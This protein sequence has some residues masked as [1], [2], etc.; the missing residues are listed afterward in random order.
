MHLAAT[1]ENSTLRRISNFFSSCFQVSPVAMSI[2]GPLDAIGLCADEELVGTWEDKPIAVDVDVATLL[3]SSFCS[4][5]LFAIV[6][7]Q[8][9]KLEFL[10]QQVELKWLMLN[11]WR[12][13]FHSSRVKWHFVKMSVSWCLVSMYRI[14]ILE[15][16]LILSNNQSKAT[17]WVLDTCLIVGL[18]PFIIILIT[19]SLS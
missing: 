12:R 3:S 10:A 18:R 6:L 17:L 11:K 13:L 16:R 14:W 1:L 7:V 4:C 19:A 9:I 8:L 5:I 2:P 15:S